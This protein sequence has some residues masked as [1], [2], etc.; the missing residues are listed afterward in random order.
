MSKVIYD[1]GAVAIKKWFRSSKNKIRPTKAL[2]AL[3][4]DLSL[5]MLEY[6]QITVR[7]GR[8]LNDHIIHRGKKARR[9]SRHKH[10]ARFRKRK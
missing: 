2:N 10:N 4:A 5:A 1:G 9:R 6:A 8:I 7:R 3:V